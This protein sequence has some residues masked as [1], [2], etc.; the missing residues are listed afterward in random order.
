MKRIIAILLVFI[1]L[2]GSAYA[3]SVVEE[4]DFGYVDESLLPKQIFLDWLHEPH[5][6][7]SVT[8]VAI[9]MGYSL[10]E[11]ET[12]IWESSWDTENWVEILNEHSQTY[13]F[14]LN[15]DV[16][17]SYLRVTAILKED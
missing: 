8:V 2:I 5:F 9:L 15:E 14:I 11:I 6:D 7:E 16:V 13:T 17:G 1:C 10:D 12:F 4:G 3:S